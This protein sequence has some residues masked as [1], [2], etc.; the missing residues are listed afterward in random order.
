MTT[1]LIILITAAALFIIYGIMVSNQ[2]IGYKNAVLQAYGSIEIYLK[3][4]FDLIPNLVSLL[5]KYMAHEKEV[6]L[7]VTELRSKTDDN[8]ASQEEKINASNEFSGLM[9]NF[10]LTAENY[11]ELKADTQFLKLQHELSDLED[12][13]SAARRA[14]NAN[15]TAYNNKIQMFPASIIAGFRKDKTQPL[16]EI[17]KAEQKEVNINQLLK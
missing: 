10:N 15:V 5:N 8:A 6:L 17:P 13:I 12:Y 16:L 14:Y 3:N 7:K 1:P 11:P 2:I 4:R 9:N